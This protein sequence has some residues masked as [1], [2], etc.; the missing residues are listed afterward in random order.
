MPLTGE[1]DLGIE[2][3]GGVQAPS[4]ED[5][6][7]QGVAFAKLDEFGD[8]A[9]DYA[10]LVTLTK[11]NTAGAHVHAFAATSKRYFCLLKGSGGGGG[12]ANS[13]ASEC[14]PASGGGEGAWILFYSPNIPAA[15][16]VDLVLA[17]GGTGGANTGA[18][19]SVGGDTTFAE[20]GAETGAI[21][22]GGGNGG[23]GSVIGLG[24]GT[25]FDV[26]PTGGATGALTVVLPTGAVELARGGLPGGRGFRRSLSTGISGDGGGGTPGRTTVG[27]GATA[28][29]PG[30]GGAGALSINNADHVGGAGLIGHAIIWEMP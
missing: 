16:T 20:T 14:A 17:A 18:N 11:Y 30:A 5:A 12:G 29:Y 6:A 27:A 9:F 7:A 15:R 22:C 28:T 24:S 25:T 1:I 13:A 4:L 2:Y 26:T 10:P 19:G 3:L 21:T 8:P 23:I